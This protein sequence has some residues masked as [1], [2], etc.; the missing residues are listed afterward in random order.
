ML[1][2]NSYKTLLEYLSIYKLCGNN[3]I[4]L[5]ESVIEPFIRKHRCPIKDRIAAIVFELTR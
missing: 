1:Q 3:G 4:K 2:N 5:Y